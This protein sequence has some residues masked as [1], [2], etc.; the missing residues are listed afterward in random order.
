M[1]FHPLFQATL[2]F[3]PFQHVTHLVDV[4]SRFQINS[5]AIASAPTGPGSGSNPNLASRFPLFK[6]LLISSLFS[7]PPHPERPYVFALL[8]CLPGCHRPLWR[9]RLRLRLRFDVICKIGVGEVGGLSSDTLMA[10]V[11]SAL[12]LSRLA[13]L[14]HGVS[15][16][17]HASC[18]LTD[19]CQDEGGLAAFLLSPAPYR[20]L[21]D[22]PACLQA[23]AANGPD[24]GS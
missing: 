19:C 24:S 22:L 8:P 2:L 11:A 23:V 4:C 10:S 3:S 17:K 21:L 5:L 9:V 12:L 20:L 14:R 7:F 6:K 15:A 13:E 18:P 16:A 1:R